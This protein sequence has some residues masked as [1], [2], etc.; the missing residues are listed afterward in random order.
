MMRRPP[1]STLF[2]YTTLFRS[3]PRRFVSLSKVAVRD[4]YGNPIGVAA[5]SHDST[6]LKLAE[7]RRLET[8]DRLKLAQ[9][10]AGLGVWDASVRSGSATCSEQWFRIY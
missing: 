4:R 3:G 2:P 5:I 1:R 7:A 8:E 9:E 6:A 10:A